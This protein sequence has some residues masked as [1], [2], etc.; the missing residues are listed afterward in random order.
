MAI[1]LESHAEP[2]PG[3]RLIER[4]GGGGFGEVW[5]AEA[6]GG[7]FKAIKFVY[8]DIE[9]AD[10][11]GA[12]AEQELK[13]LSRVKTVHHPYILSLER[14]DII[15][16]QLI[17]VMELA[18][19]TLW[20]R[21]KE[22]R[23][24][25]YVGIPRQELL[26]Y[27]R[28]S[29][30][31]LDLM[32]MQYQ[33]QHLD[34]KPQNIFLVYNHV[35][36]ADF[37]LVKDLEGMVA[38]VTGGVTPV[39]AAP[40]TFDGYVSRYSDQYSLAIVY[41]ELLTGQRPF[42]GTS[43]RQLIYQHLQA[44]PDLEPL[45]EY[46]RPIV[47]R[48]LNKEPDQRFPTCVDFV[49]ALKAA[50]S[51]TMEN[52][53][54]STDT[55]V[56]ESSFTGKSMPTKGLG[57]NAS[58]TRTEGRPDNQRP[59]SIPSLPAPSGHTTRPNVSNDAQYKKP[60][61]KPSET[62]DAVAESQVQFERERNTSDSGS[63][64]G[65]ST[66]F[67]G[68][69]Q[70]RSGIKPD[71]ETGV[72]F[73]ALVIG[74]G[75]AGMFAV[76][77]FRQQIRDVYG[78]VKNVPHIHFLGIDVDPQAIQVASRGNE[79]YT[80]RQSETF[81]LRLHRASHY[82]K[83]KNEGLDSWLPPKMLYRIP[84][85]QT[86]EGNR[87][88]G[89]LAMID[90]FSGI[91]RRLEAE[92]QSIMEAES[93]QLARE[94]TGLE[95]ATVVPKVYVLSSLAGGT[96]SGM[97]LD[98]GYIVKNVLKRQGIRHP[99]V[100]GLFLWPKVGSRGM[101]PM[102]LANAYA[103]LKELEHFGAG[104]RNF[105]ANYGR[106]DPTLTKGIFSE[107]GTPYQRCFLLT[108]DEDE[109]A[110][111]SA[112]CAQ[113]DTPIRPTTCVSQMGNLLFLE[114]FSAIGRTEERVRQNWL[115]GH[116]V[117]PKSSGPKPMVYQSAALHRVLWPRKR[118]LQLTARLLCRNLVN[119]WMSKDGKPIRESV[120]QWVGEHWL[121]LK[122]N[123]DQ[124]I[125]LLQEE[126]TSK[127]G[128]TPEATFNA[129]IDPIAEVV[130]PVTNQQKPRG[131]EDINEVKL[132]IGTVVETIEQLEQMLGIPE[133]CQSATGARGGSNSE[134][135]FVVEQL[136]EYATKIGNDIELRMAQMV[137]RLIEQPAF[138]LAGAEE[139]IRQFGKM[140]DTALE[141]QE[142]LAK[143][144]DERAVNLYNE[145]QT[146]IENPEQMPHNDSGWRLTFTRRS[147]ADNHQFARKL[148]EL[149]RAYPKCR[150]QSLILQTTTQFYISLRGQLSD[151][152]REVDFC[153]TRLRELAEK[154]T[155]ESVDE[156][157][158]SSGK[159]DLVQLQGFSG[160]L[161]LPEGMKTIAGAVNFL[162]ERISLEEISELDQ[163]IQDMIQK[164]FRALVN[165]CMTSSSVLRNLVPAM[166]GV[167][168]QFLDSRL[169]SADIVDMF[170]A[171]NSLPQE[172]EE[173]SGLS[174]E[175]RI[176]RNLQEAYEEAAPELLATSL[177]DEFCI[178]AVPPSEDEGLL[179]KLAEGALSRTRITAATSFDE[180]VLYR[181][182]LQT[183]PLENKSFARKAKEAYSEAHSSDS[184]TPHTRIDIPE[185]NLS[186]D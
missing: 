174:E 114:L 92:I 62:V 179:R 28:E 112:E 98:L 76:N 19:Q 110:R 117:D 73:P 12:R 105:V 72:L 148:L 21:F 75:S 158:N 116:S 146:L 42:A 32:N 163:A 44:Q 164:N 57:D 77:R 11:E 182:Q 135:G 127:F 34:I 31:A 141:R 7:L 71:A 137:V 40:E 122:I 2:I 177:D 91:V 101:S 184:F 68:K 175:D 124:L 30:E 23:S 10:E 27:M 1:K 79:L 104:D 81:Q 93:L 143:E 38:S 125:R 83:H 22:C 120:K 96:G 25:G 60:P 90:S 69:H 161:L 66:T 86:P 46:E 87:A 5:K 58:G 168:Q 140:V 173:P 45:P 36:V 51:D 160:E 180:I 181:E 74:L 8:G 95:F 145:I 20:D 99:E 118:L 61:P 59:G 84:R 53:S 63:R 151:Q 183:S 156:K 85:Q 130:V 123:P 16:G 126:I 153:R 29:A 157:S 35:K 159:R 106:S 24:K 152:L 185:W 89:R 80:L 111:K 154:L 39:Y 165:V 43:V 82:I 147:T 15:D 119:G 6:P 108:S 121:D 136:K 33:L 9:A 64:L 49:E 17:I 54:L 172:G 88:L 41:Q 70:K 128:N 113:S 171:R 14:Y 115:R 166:E 178:F 47:A 26:S 67:K 50:G 103:A 138:R 169:E 142:Y 107:S 186:N 133:G 56:L 102:G 170:L 131:R 3:Y 144:L 149:L 109:F 37:G 65:S 78:D 97:L 13:A 139:T 4:L 162:I 132:Q 176:K 100:V 150:F 129:L 48:A 18:D 167:A 94:N 55:S 52:F 155:D 134:L